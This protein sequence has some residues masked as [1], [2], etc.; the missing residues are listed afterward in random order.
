MLRPVPTHSGLATGVKMLAEMDPEY[1]AANLAEARGYA[2]LRLGTSDIGDHVHC[3]VCW[4]AIAAWTH[5]H[6]YRAEHAAL[7]PTCH[8]RH[9]PPN[10]R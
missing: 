4:E 2:W 10:D 7:C 6:F 3:L 5:D 9:I 8:D 1:L